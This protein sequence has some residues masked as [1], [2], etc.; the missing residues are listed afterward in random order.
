MVNVIPGAHIDLLANLV[1]ALKNFD[2]RLRS[3]LVADD[4]SVDE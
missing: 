4:F 3:L 2:L 1:S